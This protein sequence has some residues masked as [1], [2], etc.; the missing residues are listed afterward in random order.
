MNHPT[1]PVLAFVVLDSATGQPL[2]APA[3][4][5]YLVTDPDASGAGGALAATARSIPWDEG[6][7]G[8]VSYTAWSFPLCEDASG[9]A[10]SVYPA[11][12]CVSLGQ[13]RFVVSAPGYTSENVVVEVQPGGACA[14][15]LFA[16]AL[17]SDN[18]QAE[19]TAYSTAVVSL[20]PTANGAP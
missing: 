1:T 19:A 3:F 12:G 18:V 7:G 10:A 6:D 8:L 4:A 13:Y 11:S 15:G 17:P 9:A 5:A 16:Q 20:A 2:A 14:P